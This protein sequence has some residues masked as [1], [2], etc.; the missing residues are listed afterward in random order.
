MNINLPNV[1]YNQELFNALEVTR[2]GGTAPLFDQMFAGLTLPGLPAAYGPVGT[3]VNGVVQHG[4]AQLRRSTAVTGTNTTFE[5][6]LANGNY[7]SI[8]A[9]LHTLTAGV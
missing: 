8:A 4:S 5:S 2:A 3:T 1:Y 7:Q 9:L 6:D